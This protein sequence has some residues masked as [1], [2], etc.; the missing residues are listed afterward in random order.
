M[1]AS[2]ATASTANFLADAALLFPRWEVDDE[3]S[4]WGKAMAT[5]KPVLIEDVENHELIEGAQLLNVKKHGIHSGLLV[6]LL[7]NDTS[8]GVI[9]VNDTR[10]RRFTEDEVSL[11]MAF[12]DQ[13]ALA[14]EK[15]RLLNEA[16]ARERQATQLYEVTTQL[17]SNHDLD[18]V[19]ELITQQAAELMNARAG[20]I[21]RFDEERGGLVVTTMYNLIPAM[22]GLLVKP[23]EGNA[24]RAYQER[25]VMWTN[26]LLGEVKYS[27]SETDQL[28]KE[29][30]SDWGVVGVVAAPI[31]IQEEV[32]G[33]L[34]VIFDEHREFTD[35]EVN[36]VQNLADSAAV[37][38]NNARFIEET[39]RARDEATQLYEITEQLASSHDMD[40]V[41]DLIATKAV[42][43]L[44]CQG[45]AIFE[46]DPVREGLV[47]VKTYNFLSE[48]VESLFFRP[49]EGTPG[50]AFQQ[51]KP[52]WTRDRFSD[53]S[54]ANSDTDSETAARNAGVR[55]AASV[56]I[57]IRGQPYGVIN[58]L[59][60]QPHDFTDGD[61]QLLQTL[62]D[63]AAVAIG[64]AR[65]IEDTERSRDEATQL[66]GITEQL[67]SATDMD[68]VL[69]LITAKATE[70]LGSR[71]SSIHRYDGATDSLLHAKAHNVAPVM[72]ERYSG[73]PGI[74]V[75]GIAFQERRPVWSSDISADPTINRSEGDA[76]RALD[77]AGLKAVL[78]VPI[79]VRDEPYGILNVFYLE[80]HDFSDAE[81]RLLSTMADS[82]AVAIGNARFIE[83]TEQ[84]RDDA[85][86]REQEATQ[87]QE[88]TAQLASS[89]DM[90][91]VLA[92]ITQKAVELLKPDGSGILRYDSEKGGLVIAQGLDFLERLTPDILILPG[93]GTTGRSFQTRGVVWSGD[94][95]NDGTFNY[96]DETT[97]KA[98]RDL[99]PQSALSA[100]IIIR[101]EPY[102]VL[103][104]IY[105]TP[106][107]FPR[108]ER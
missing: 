44:G 106:Y 7:A 1:V 80:S 33:V 18:S 45:S 57:I 34:D 30:V 26:D 105:Y 86:A 51:R 99:A 17:A 85:Q 55:G 62:A 29:Q 93:E 36:L 89:T 24:E 107:E 27:D 8:I 84:S 58:I 102:G 20:A 83:E 75:T 71:G 103:V 19:L 31:V 14:L 49:G 79:V 16:E 90:G 4:V 28:V 72:L 60:F 41:L 101:D 10:T 37:A 59:F 23:G 96:S 92:L 78:S 88:I 11:L 5:K 87:L 43:L 47:A 94:P 15:A 66:Y 91:S 3:T 74:G 6:P 97:D 67:A 70:M 98:L 95:Y 22:R 42:E 81:V 21:F 38:I 63:S 40:S 69:D 76:R 13:A 108:R 104:V 35:E 12:A 100:P 64:N 77:E 46:Y 39:E 56:P 54:I 65:F 61:I 9:N 50:S 53:P 48:M 73:K 2:A 52:V 25:R 82:A 32:Y 68:S